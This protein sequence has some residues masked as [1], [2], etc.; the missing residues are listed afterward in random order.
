MYYTSMIIEQELR[1]INH[2]YVFLALIHAL[3]VLDLRFHVPLV[4]IPI[5]LFLNL[6]LV[7][8]HVHYLII[9]I[10]I[11]AQNVILFV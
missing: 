4:Q 8:N 3:L 1:F 2:R 11:C 7:R 6:I 9:K 5:F 10:A